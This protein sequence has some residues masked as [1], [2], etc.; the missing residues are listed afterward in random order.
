VVVVS[1]QTVGPYAAVQLQSTDPTALSQ[2]LASNGYEIPTDVQP[3]IAAYLNEGF[4]FLA[5]KLLPGLGIQAM[6]PVRVTT[7]GA[8][9]SLPLR[10]VA[11]GTGATVGITLWV[12][13]DGRYEPRNFQSFT[14]AASELTWNFAAGTSDY[15]TI[16]AQKEAQ[17][18]Q[19]AWQ[20]ESSVLVNPLNIEFV[21]LQQAND[22]AAL[23]AADGGSAGPGASSPGQARLD[24]LGAL[25]PTGA[26]SVRITRLSADLSHAA[27]ATDLTLEA[28]SDQS[29]LT[30]VYP[31]T[32]Y[33]NAPACPPASACN[34]GGASSSSSS[35]SNQ[36]AVNG[37]SPRQEGFGCAASTSTPRDAELAALIGFLAAAASRLRKRR[38]S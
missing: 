20:T 7:P 13:S 3:V 18:G 19:A 21:V 12:V 22:Y 29:V 4:D 34:C 38:S 10:M 8:A 14:V 5:L 15:T 16:R 30:N 36:G 37:S 28:S 35:G 32:N 31:V 25:F 27:L 6:R 26:S 17:Y 1:Q 9:L 2:W 33:V 24:D 23:P 11:A